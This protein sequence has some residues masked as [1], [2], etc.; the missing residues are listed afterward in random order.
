[1]TGFRGVVLATGE[2]SIMSV[3]YGVQRAVTDCL[4]QSGGEHE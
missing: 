1:V 4:R 3:R 2:R